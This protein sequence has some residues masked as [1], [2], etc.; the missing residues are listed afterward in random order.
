MMATMRGSFST[1]N[2]QE[3]L[4]DLLIGKGGLQKLPGELKFKK[5]DKWDG[6][7]APAL[8]ENLEDL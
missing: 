4:T 6:K 7:N 8:E 3:F 1:Q 5:A 2:L